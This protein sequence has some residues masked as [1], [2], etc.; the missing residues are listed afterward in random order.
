VCVCVYI[1]CVCVSSLKVCW[2]SV[3]IQKAKFMLPTFVRT[4]LTNFRT[5]A[6]HT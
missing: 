2:Q 4:E 1:V 3:N 5:F 6:H